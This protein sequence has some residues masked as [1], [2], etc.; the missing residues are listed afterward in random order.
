VDRAALGSTVVGEGTKIDNLVQ[1][2]HNVTLG[3]HCILCGQVGIAGSTKVGSYVTMAGQV[4]VAG[5]LTI[6][7]KATLGAQSGLMDDVPEGQTWLF[8]PA[9]PDRQVKR[10]F[11]AMQ[12]LPELLRR[13][14]ELEKQLAEKEIGPGD[15]A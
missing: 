1:V 11:I 7:N 12:R 8:T 6:G 15:N 5:H 2:G 14:S 10:M 9:Q 3:E 13:V 4:G